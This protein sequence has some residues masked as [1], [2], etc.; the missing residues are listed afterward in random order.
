M[1][2]YEMVYVEV[3]YAGKGVRVH[4]TN[5]VLLGY[6]FCSWCNSPFGL[7]L[8]VFKFKFARFMQEIRFWD[9]RSWY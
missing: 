3:P 4:T 2:W 8:Q 7:K 9:K 6:Q 5:Q 1:V